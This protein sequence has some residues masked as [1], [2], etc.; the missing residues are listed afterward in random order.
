MDY[1]EL[2]KS[3]RI[4]TDEYTCVG[5]IKNTEGKDYCDS[6]NCD[7]ELVRDAADAIEKLS[8]MYTEERNTAVELTGELASKPR[9][10]PVTE[11]Q[12]GKV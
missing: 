4:C 1:T 10:I 2:V 6:I 8:R 11:E 9:W 12:D 7:I 3:L 5:C